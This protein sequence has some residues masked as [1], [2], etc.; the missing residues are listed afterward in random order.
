M[1]TSYFLTDVQKKNLDE[2]AKRFEL[3]NIKTFRGMEVTGINATLYENG[4]KLCNCD[5]SGDGGCLDFSEY[6]V[7]E[8]LTN[9]LKNLIGDVKFSAEYVTNTEYDAECFVN[10]LIS[11][12]LENKEFKSKCKRNTLII[13]TDCKDGQFII[14]KNL[15][16][17]PN[18][19]R[20]LLEKKYGNKLVEIINERFV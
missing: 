16:F 19:T 2:F 11:E 7:Q 6:A 3:K 9:A 4:K 18:T 8:R 14:H 12:A 13:T 17:Y 15:P 10:D 1:K 20:Q 5:D